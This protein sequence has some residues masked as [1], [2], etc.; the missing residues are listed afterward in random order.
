MSQE[1]KRITD[2]PEATEIANDDYVFIDNGVS[3][4]KFLAKNL[5]GAEPVKIKYLCYG[6]CETDNGATEVNKPLTITQYT[7]Y[8]TFLSYDSTNDQIE[9][10]QDFEAIIVPWV[11]C[12]KEAGGRPQMGLKLNGNWLAR[13]LYAENSVGSAGGLAFTMNEYVTAN[14]S[15]FPNNSAFN[16]IRIKLSQGDTLSMQKYSDTGWASARIKIY[17]LCGS[18][19]AIDNFFDSICTLSDTSSATEISLDN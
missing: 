9:V 8:T 14:Q 6:V 16:A 17:K 7:D 3:S 12:Y 11:Y 1:I 5:G 2:Y 18:T 4:K 19:T 13:A 10:L 15:Y